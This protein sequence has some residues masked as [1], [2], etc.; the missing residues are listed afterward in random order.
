MSE[1][2]SKRFFFEKKKQKTFTLLVRAVG[3]RRWLASALKESKFFCFFLFTKRSS[4]L[5]TSLVAAVPVLKEH[6]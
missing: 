2:V 6:V 4:S 1:K 5:L 3:Q